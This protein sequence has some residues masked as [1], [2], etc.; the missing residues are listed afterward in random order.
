MEKQLV[1]DNW[2]KKYE[3]EFSELW[4]MHLLDIKDQSMTN[5]AV[6]CNECGSGIA[7]LCQCAYQKFKDS[8]SHENIRHWLRLK[9]WHFCWQYTYRNEIKVAWIKNIY[10]YQ[11][12]ETEICQKCNILKIICNCAREKFISEITKYKLFKLYYL[13]SQTRKN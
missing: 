13:H 12:N 8:I 3:K 5:L 2:Q 11:S 7:L 4:N 9:S 6:S 10:Y 1:S